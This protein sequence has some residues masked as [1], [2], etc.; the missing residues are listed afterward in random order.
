VRVDP[1]DREV[2]PRRDPQVGIHA[3]YHDMPVVDIEW[4]CR[5]DDHWY[6]V[7]ATVEQRA[8]QEPPP[9]LAFEFAYPGPVTSEM[10]VAGTI[11]WMKNRAW[12]VVGAVLHEVDVEGYSAARRSHEEGP[13]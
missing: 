13:G 12:R 9:N 4:F 1:V 3:I 8:Q 5:S 7:E 6:R 2:S 11:G 10:F